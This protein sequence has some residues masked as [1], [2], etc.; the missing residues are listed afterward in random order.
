MNHTSPLRRFWHTAFFVALS[1]AI[2][3]LARPAVA[4]TYAGGGTYTLTGTYG[5]VSVVG[6]TT[7]ITAPGSVLEHLY[8]YNQSKGIINGGTVTGSTPADGG[9]NFS[10]V[11]EG[12]SL[13]T[14]NAGTL[15]LGLSVANRSHA[16]VNGGTINYALYAFN[17]SQLTINGGSAT[18]YFEGLSNSQITM[19]GGQTIGMLLWH[20]SHAIIN[21]GTLSPGI[22][23]DRDG[24]TIIQEVIAR[25]NSVLEVRGGTLN[26]SPA[27][28]G[29]SVIAY[30]N[31]TIVLTG[32]T[33]SLGL[34]TPVRRADSSLFG[35]MYTLSGRFL[36]GTSA[37]G[38][39][40]YKRDA[41]RIIVNNVA[42]EPASLL[43]LLAAGP[44][45]LWRRRQQRRTK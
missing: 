11:S 30:D 23:L 8:T 37:N 39:K 6:T 41:A 19:N 12:Q 10:V 36:D 17:D 16:V 42:P 34:G 15:S 13:I 14:M 20:Q 38:V 2:A 22:F 25:D 18:G 43:F 27:D 9:T 26:P 3:G 1:S 29:Y 28:G 5:A 35:T 40:I 32:M 24:S 33:I 21:G 7:V 31:A 44:Y 45:A 4:Q